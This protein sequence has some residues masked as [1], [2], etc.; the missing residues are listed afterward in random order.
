M[1]FSSLQKPSG[2]PPGT[3][4][5]SSGLE[6][7]SNAAPRRAATSSSEGCCSRCL[8]PS[9]LR[10]WRP[11]ASQK[12]SPT[13]GPLQCGRARCG[14]ALP[15][16]GLE[17]T[18]CSHARG[19]GRCCSRRKPRESCN[20]GD[21]TGFVVYSSFRNRPWLVRCSSSSVVLSVLT[22]ISATSR[23]PLAS[24]KNC[25]YF[26]FFQTLLCQGGRPEDL[27]GAIGMLVM[28]CSGSG[29]SLE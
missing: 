18:S 7:H 28:I 29:H 23:C 19:P 4:Q 10:L 6:I 3:R 15:F 27:S 21:E 13:D 8:V 11:V 25:G 9:R 22:M 24:H 2:T 12:Q 1:P 16:R 14:T 20:L 5:S 26:L 17:A